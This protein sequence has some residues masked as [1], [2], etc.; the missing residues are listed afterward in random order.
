M[1]GM[2][3]HRREAAPVDSRREPPAG[4]SRGVVGVRGRG[5]E[6][7]GTAVP[8]PGVLARRVA[9]RASATAQGGR[10]NQGLGRIR[11]IRV[12]RPGGAACRRARRG[13]RRA[14]GSALG[15][16]LERKSVVPLSR[17]SLLVGGRVRD[18]SSVRRNGDR[19]APGAALHSG[20]T[21]AR[22]DGVA[23][24]LAKLLRPPARRPPLAELPARIE[25]IDGAGRVPSPSRRARCRL[26]TK[27]TSVARDRRRLARP[28][29]TVARTIVDHPGHDD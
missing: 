13:G 3:H 24:G 20:G 1:A 28:R 8:D 19:H 18:S 15:A 21:N 17:R 25:W 5:R 22:C 16:E 23:R 29:E 11:A 26:V 6:R 4:S 12:R 9:G 2:G 14:I 10:A 27:G 7:E